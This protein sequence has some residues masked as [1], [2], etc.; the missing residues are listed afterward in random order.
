MSHIHNK[1]AAEIIKKIP[2]ITLATVSDDGQP[3]NSPL[4]SVYDKDLNFY[5]VSDQKSVHSEDLRSNNKVFCVIY[6]ST[7]AEGTGEGVYFKGKAFELA[8]REVLVECPTREKPITFKGNDILKIY[9]VVPEK[10]W[11]NDDEK[12]VNGK[13]V[14]DIKVEVPQDVLKTQHLF[15]TL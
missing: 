6:D 14:R 7:M 10:I 9:K 15:R 3:W 2:Y 8:E 1:K 11:M 12:D 4:W 5:W 13:Y